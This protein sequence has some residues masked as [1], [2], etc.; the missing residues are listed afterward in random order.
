MRKMILSAAVLALVA[1]PVLAGKYNKK[2]SVGDKAPSFEG[3]PAHNPLTGEATS[4]T[5]PDVKEDV[6]VLA[7]LGNHCPVVQAYEDRIIDF[8]NDYKGKSVKVIGVSVNDSDSD[9]L[10]AI[11]TYTKDKGSNYVYG[12]DESQKIGRDYGATNTPQFFVLDKDRTIRYMGS[13]DDDM[14]PSKATKTY[15]RDAVDALL[16][17]TEIAVQ[18][19]QPKGCGVQYKR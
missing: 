14:N 1:S 10:P 4:L 9:R 18:E 16:A 6:V 8:V 11:K 15:L 19:T 2:V 13:L 5:L 3:I 7:F 17:G 12:Y